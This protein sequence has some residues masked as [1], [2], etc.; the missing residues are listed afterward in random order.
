MVECGE[1]YIV[2]Y[3][4]SVTYDDSSMILKMTAR[5]DEHLFADLDVLAEICI[6]RW[7]DTQ[8]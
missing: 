3:L 2:A 7:E 4:T 1:D 5:I 8:G 6:E